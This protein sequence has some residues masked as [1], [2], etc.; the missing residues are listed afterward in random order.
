MICNGS[1]DNCSL[2][3]DYSLL[4]F[5]TDTGSDNESQ[6][7]A[8]LKRKFLVCS[9]L[10]TLCMCS[11]LLFNLITP[12]AAHKPH[13]VGRLCRRNR[14]FAEA[15]T[16]TTHNF[17]NRQTSMPPA[18]FEPAIPASERQ[19]TY[20][21]DRAPTGVGKTYLLLSFKRALLF[22]TFISYILINLYLLL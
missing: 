16:C 5:V 2:M 14:P 9:L 3:S 4:S 12:N 8:C 17:H 19:Q 10:S 13:S 1:A 7:F 15:S 20:A 11:G 22:F 6:K 21:L 18:V